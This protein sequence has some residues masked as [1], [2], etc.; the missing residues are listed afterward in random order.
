MTLLCTPGGRMASKASA[1]YMPMLEMVKLPVLYSLGDSCLLRARFTRSCRWQTQCEPLT[2]QPSVNAQPPCQGNL[3]RE[4][5]DMS[6]F[7][8]C[9]NI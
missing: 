5:A 3:G 6:S 9:A 8:L 4:A 1:P 2:H 7:D